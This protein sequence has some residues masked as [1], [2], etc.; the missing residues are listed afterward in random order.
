M[1]PVWGVGEGVEGLAADESED[2]KS[3]DEETGEN[4]SNFVNLYK[5]SNDLR[6]RF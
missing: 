1:P 5:K 3:S 6:K 2:K 4:I